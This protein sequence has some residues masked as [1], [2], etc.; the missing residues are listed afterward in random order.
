[1]VPEEAPLTITFPEVAKAAGHACPAVA[2]AYRVTQLA[3]AEL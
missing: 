3:L 2:G 1:M